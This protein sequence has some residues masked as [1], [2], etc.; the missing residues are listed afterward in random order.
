MT[1]VYNNL[2]SNCVRIETRYKVYG[3]LSRRS[4]IGIVVILVGASPVC[5]EVLI[6]SEGYCWRT[7]LR[8]HGMATSPK[9]CRYGILL[10]NFAKRWQND[11][12]CCEPFFR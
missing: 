10:L 9:L 6:E 4:R 3:N 11:A 7:D 12:H 5:G 1:V 8:I 2:Q